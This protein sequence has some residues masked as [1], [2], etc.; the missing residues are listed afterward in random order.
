MVRIL[1]WN[2]HTNKNKRTKLLQRALTEVVDENNIDIVILQEAFGTFVN[3]ALNALVTQYDEILHLG[4]STGSGVRMFVK[5]NA[6]SYSSIK[7]FH[8]NKLLL[9]SFKRNGGIEDFNIAAVHLHSKVGNTERQ[10]LWK[11]QPIFN[12]VKK[13]EKGSSNN[14]TI[15]VGDFNHNPY[16]SNLCDPFLINCKDSRQLISTLSKNPISK[17]RNQDYWY[18]PMWNLLG[19]HDFRNG[20]ERVTGTYFRYT[21]DETPI[22]N[23]LDGVIIRPS[24]MDRVDY[25][26]SAIITETTTVKFL[27]KF[28]IRKDESLIYEDLSDHLPVKF[29]IDIN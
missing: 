9:A 25:N 24:I 2:I 17:S 16:D 3:T 11:N 22:W 5:Q 4:S 21:E 7:K 6:F 8:R 13:F 12:E 1:S 27:K 14:R 18:N 19:D 20:K 28:T 26:E 15:I 23:L 10:Q 29:A